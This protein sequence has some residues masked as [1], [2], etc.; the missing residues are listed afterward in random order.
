MLS[1]LLSL[2]C[3]GAAGYIAGRLMGMRGLWYIYV[4]LGLVGGLVG[5]LAFSL[6]GL[7]SISPI[8]NMIIS[9]IGACIVV[10][11]YRKLKK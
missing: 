6:I 2:A 9:I 10:F 7:K 11:L 1:L 3:S 8:G 5:D 4:A